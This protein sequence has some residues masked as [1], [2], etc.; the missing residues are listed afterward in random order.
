[1]LP[2]RY[3]T[4]KRSSLQKILGKLFFSHAEETK[5]DLY[6]TPLTKINSKWITDLNVRTDA[7]KLIEE[8]TQFL[9]NSLGNKFL[10]MTLKAQ[11]TKTTLSKKD[12]VK[13]ES[14]YRAKEKTNK[15]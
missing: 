1:M 15:M 7:I 13:L 12:N 10:D 6:L 11:A 3:L 5:L 8:N 4:G 2:K 14:S 9:D